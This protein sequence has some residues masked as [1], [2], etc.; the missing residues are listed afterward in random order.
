VTQTLA[1]IV[2]VAFAAYRL[3]AVIS[4]D[5]ISEP[6]RVWVY[7]R[8]H[9]EVPPF[10]LEDAAEEVG[11]EPGEISAATLD[12]IR[13]GH[14]PQDHL[15]IAVE[16]RKAG[17]YASGWHWFYGLISCPFCCGW[18]LSLAGWWAYTGE[19][20]N[21]RAWAIQA[22]AVAGVQSAIPSNRPS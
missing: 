17:V 19:F 5:T 7:E 10:I 1:A 15:E 21:S 14:L 22:V 18:W 11:E 12:K 4:L 8:G 16:E 3:A 9:H 6:F 13:F 2:I 20:M